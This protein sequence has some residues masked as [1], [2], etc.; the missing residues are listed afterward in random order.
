MTIK[1]WVIS[2][3]KSADHLESLAVT[4]DNLSDTPA[5]F[6]IIK[7]TL[8]GGLS[9]GVEVLQVNN[10]KLQFDLLLTRG[11]SLASATIGEVK[12]GWQSPVRGPVHPKFVNLHEPSGLGWLDGFDEMMVR[13]GLE[14]NGAPEFDSETNNL[15]YCV[16]GRI[17]NKPADQVVV[18]VDT[19]AETISIKAVVVEVRFH[20]FKVALETTIVTRFND[21]ALQI[22][23]TIRNLSASPTA[24]Q[25]LYHCNY[26]EPLLGDGAQVIVPIKELVPRNDHAAAGMPNW[27][28][29]DAPKTGFEEQ[30]YFLTLL[31]D[32]A[33]D[34]EVLLKNAQSTQGVNLAYNVNQLP[35]F[36]MWKNTTAIEDGYVTGIE[37]GTNYPN[38]RSFEA[39]HGREISLSGNSSSQLDLTMR[40]LVDALQ[41]DATEKRIAVLQGSQ[42]PIIH[43]TPQA[44]WC[45]P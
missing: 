5:K 15:K 34:T 19:Q 11:M 13:C 30:V 12:F 18:T 21:D 9:D 35:C 2:D 17:G 27:S 25:V 1:T 32:A 29:Y 4:S 37:P 6:S 45:A 8:R 20:L 24:A 31:G 39:T 10:G 36:S 14:S 23:D 41:I 42:Q 43:T 33:G 3:T 26:G 44:D 28:R 7:K 38:P 22:H 16:H 40:F